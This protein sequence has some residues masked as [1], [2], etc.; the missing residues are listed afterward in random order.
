MI[1]APVMHPPAHRDQFAKKGTL[2][3]DRPTDPQQW[4]LHGEAL[5]ENGLPD[6]EVAI[7]EDVLGAEVDETQG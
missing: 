2:E 1:V 5:D 7:A 4:N 6:D 3:G